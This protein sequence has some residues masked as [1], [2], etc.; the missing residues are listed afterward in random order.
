MTSKLSNYT[1]SD[2]NSIQI[3]HHVSGRASGRRF[4]ISGL[5]DELLFQDLYKKAKKLSKAA[6]NSQNIEELKILKGFTL[7]LLTAETEAK[8][9]YQEQSCIY[10]IITAI[11]RFIGATPWFGTHEKRVQS[12]L[13][14][15]EK[16]LDLAPQETIAI[17]WLA[18]LENIPHAP[19][20]VNILEESKTFQETV[21]R[22]FPGPNHTAK[23]VE[24][25]PAI[26]DEI[27]DFAKRAHTLIDT[28]VNNLITAFLQNKRSQGSIEEKA[29]YQDISTEDF[30]KRL[31]EKRPLG[32]YS[33]GMAYLRD[34]TVAE[35][36]TPLPLQ[37]YL[38]ND[39]MQIS[40]FLVT[41]TPTHF[42]N[43][44]ES[45]NVGNK[46]KDGTFQRDGIYYGISGARL[47]R[48][49]L[50]EEELVYIRPDRLPKNI[51]TWLSFL[52]SQPLFSGVKESYETTMDESIFFK[53]SDDCYLHKLAYK[54]I[55]EARISA[56][57]K[58][59][60]NQAIALG[61]KAY[62]HVIP[63]GLEFS[64]FRE[65]LSPHLKLTLALIQK[66]IYKE[67]LEKHAFTHI[68]TLN[69]SRF[70]EA[71]IAEEEPIGTIKVFSSNR[72]TAEKL[73]DDNL[74]LCA[75]Y[76]ANPGC[77]P[78]NGYWQNRV[79]GEDSAPAICST[80]AELQNPYINPNISNL[81]I[82]K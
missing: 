13:N 23:F 16:N 42:V 5:P 34:K 17:E 46:L 7:K 8:K 70:P 60:N 39:E 44:G 2:L 15:L 50:M 30:V 77:L 57:L 74:L 1:P 76:E 11:Q 82:Y 78:G 27:N 3:N 18:C 22:M 40:A 12:L 81:Y 45:L 62:L 56:Y 20:D 54:T 65:S 41:A 71:K 67:Q 25:D 24:R 80:I 36:D 35:K 64:P 75:Q 37:D 52:Q 58:D 61:K 43:E 73:E 31:L 49:S 48:E 4:T 51:F 19:I 79:T 55:M 26:E 33:T 53:V 68:D 63:L 21:C 32:Y 29:L 72:D 14:K 6:I 10:R 9:E 59:A 69:F 66:Q 38:S 28:S 47:N